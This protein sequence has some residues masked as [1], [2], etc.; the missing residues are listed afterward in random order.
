[1]SKFLALFLSIYSLMHL[2]F[3]LR[4][5][6]LL[7]GKTARAFFALFL[8][9]MILTPLLSRILEKSGYDLPARIAG[10]AGFY[11]MGFIF[12]GSVA[13]ILM[14]ATDILSSLILRLTPFDFPA[15]SGKKPVLV[16]LASLIFLCIYGIIEA[17]QIRIASL[18]LK[19]HKLPA[20]TESFRIV[21]ISDLHLGIFTRAGSVREIAD[22][23]RSLNP[24]I[25]VCTG[26][27]VDGA[28]HSLKGLS[29]IFNE[30]R[31]EYGKYAVTGNHEYYAGLDHSI[32]FMQDCGF[33]VLRGKAETLPSLITVAGID[34]WVADRAVQEAALLSSAQ[35]GL[36]V[37]FLKH[38]PVVRKETL[39]TFDL[40]LSGHTHGGQIFP[41]RFI[42]SA[43]FPFLRGY[44]ELSGGSGIYVN[45]GTGT[46]GPQMRIFSPPEIT[47]IELKRK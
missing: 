37:L 8:A 47:L 9:I 25:L 36:F 2:L 21:Q 1:M 31:P 29:D 26:D 23:I 40:Q 30:I 24:D 22:K 45:P 15:L 43:F 20:G 38:R 18:H 12:L 19:T 16:M 13:A 7:P 44:Y 10:F 33:T 14:S 11:W 34:D 41:F 42:V 5:R 27:M 46:W 39:G 3:F 4:V 32:A 28:A 6:V 17:R 35:K